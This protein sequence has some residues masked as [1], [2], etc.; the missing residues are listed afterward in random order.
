MPPLP[1]LPLLPPS[2][3]VL[4]GEIFPS[5]PF[6]LLLLLVLC[7]DEAEDDGAAEDEAGMTT[8]GLCGAVSML[9]DPEDTRSSLSSSTITFGLLP[10]F[11]DEAIPSSLF[12]LFFIY[13]WL[14]SGKKKTNKQMLHMS[15]YAMRIDVLAGGG[16]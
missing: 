5:A 10:S 2:S 13:F 4:L 16:R 9:E 7:D 11:C 8:L 1:L 3:D 15:R 14:G 12:Y 6:V